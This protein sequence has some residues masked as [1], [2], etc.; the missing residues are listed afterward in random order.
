M[1]NDGSNAYGE[2]TI[3]LGNGDGSFQGPVVYGLDGA[4]PV[5]AGVGDFNGDHIPDL[6]VVLTTNDKVDILLGVGD[7][8]F[9]TA[10]VLAGSLGLLLL[11]GLLVDK[12]PQPG[13]VLNRL[14]CAVYVFHAEHV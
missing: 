11:D 6:A 13:P 4:V 5:W 8:T 1:V 3:L 2:L 14:L 9:G 10:V 12:A 7:G